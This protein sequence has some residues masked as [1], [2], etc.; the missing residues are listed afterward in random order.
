MGYLSASEKG[1]LRAGAIIVVMAALLAGIASDN[2][3]SGFLI[4]ALVCG[5]AL[6]AAMMLAR[7]VI[8]RRN[9]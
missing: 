1:G 7:A 4:T 6:M 3:L 9:R 2:F 8:S 5:I